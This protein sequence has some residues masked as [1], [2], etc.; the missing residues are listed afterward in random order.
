MPIILGI[1]GATI[2]YLND[3]IQNFR[4]LDSC[5]KSYVE[6][7][8]LEICTTLEISDVNTAFNQRQNA[9]SQKDFAWLFFGIAHLFNV[10]EAFVDRHLIN[11][12]TSDDLTFQLGPSISTN[13][14]SN[15]QFS[16]MVS[17]DLFKITIPLSK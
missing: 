7:D 3:R 2:W 1:E 15:Q 5:W 4:S 13:Q 12:D 10:I 11:F 9:R 16:N 17:V 14:F 6:S 8:P